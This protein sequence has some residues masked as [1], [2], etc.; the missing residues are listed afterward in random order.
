MSVRLSKIKKKEEMHMLTKKSFLSLLDSLAPEE[1][2]EEVEELLTKVKNDFD[3]R[4]GYLRTFG[5]VVDDDEIESFEYTPNEVPEV[6]TE[7]I[8]SLRAENESLKN[9]LAESKQKYRDRFFY[10]S[11]DESED[12]PEED[13]V[14]TID[15]LLKKED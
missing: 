3:E 9:D 15:D 12:D 13:E 7:E 10:G 11:P 5:T 1:L 14:I 6:N 8:D 4:D 2:T